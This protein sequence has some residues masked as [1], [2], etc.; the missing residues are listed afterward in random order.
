MA[1]CTTVTRQAATS[2]ELCVK[3]GTHRLTINL[4]QNA[5]VSSAG[6]VMHTCS[7]LIQCRVLS[8]SGQ[9]SGCCTSISSLLPSSSWGL[10]CAWQL[11]SHIWL[12]CTICSRR[13]CLN[14]LLGCLLALPRASLQREQVSM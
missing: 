9:P 5:F 3:Q 11:I 13:P 10:S 4:L 12:W 2:W 8:S 1:G 14:S 7:C 6:G